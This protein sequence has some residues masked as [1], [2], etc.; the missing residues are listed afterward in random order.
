MFKN[1]YYKAVLE[2]KVN[3]LKIIQNIQCI[4]RI[5]YLKLQILINEQLLNFAL[6][7]VILLY[8]FIW[9]FGFLWLQCMAV[10]I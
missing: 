6:R 10:K 7:T 1:R 4:I 2:V 5:C 8:F 3:K 9:G